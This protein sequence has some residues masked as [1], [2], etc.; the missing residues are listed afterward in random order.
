MRYLLLSDV[1]ANGEAM[2]A[3]VKHARLRRWDEAVFLG[4]AVG[5]YA[6]PERAIEQLRELD[7]SVTILGNHGAMLLTLVDGG[8]PDH[9]EDGL[10]MEIL[11]RHA[12]E[13]SEDGVTYLREFSSGH[14]ADGWEATH[15]ALRSQWEYLATV[16]NAQGNVDHLS[17]RICF[18]GHT[19][20]PVV[21]AAVQTPAGDMWRTAPFRKENS[22]YRIPPM[23]KIFFNPGSV[24]QPRDG[25][26]LASYA[27]YD[28]ASS[29]V[30]IFRV[31]FDLLGV[32]RTL[33]QRGYPEVLA[34]RLV[35]GK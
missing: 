30:E 14:I 29:T 22:I 21:F 12:H 9:K 7:P 2:A 33:R 4:D 16:S 28:T 10:V 17:E 6:E 35:V 24:G 34:H 1:H 11:A 3:M 18:V 15:G 8:T 26:P 19:H 32:Q 23:A 20:V 27:I 25:I 5:Y 31:E 13:L